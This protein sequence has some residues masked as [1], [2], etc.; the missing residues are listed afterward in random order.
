[1]TAVTPCTWTFVP[2]PPK[3]GPPQDVGAEPATS[4]PAAEAFQEMLEFPRILVRE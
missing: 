4:T 2:S 1:M 3:A